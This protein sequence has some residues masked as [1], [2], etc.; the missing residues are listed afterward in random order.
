MSEDDKTLDAAVVEEKRTYV[1]DEGEV[2]TDDLTAVVDSAGHILATDEVVTIEE[3]D[4][5]AAMDETVA[6]ADDK[7]ELHVVGETVGAIDTEGNAV[8]ATAIAEADDDGDED[9]A[10]GSEAGK[11][12][13]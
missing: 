13:A 10:S 7:G 1:T 8:V 11:A 9:G 3:P 4:G 6:V 5:S 12:G 2:V